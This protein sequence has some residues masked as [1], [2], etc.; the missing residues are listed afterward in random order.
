MSKAESQESA[1]FY[2]LDVT[3]S[4]SDQNMFEKMGNTRASSVIRLAPL[5]ERPKLTPIRSIGDY[6]SN[7]NI[8]VQGQGVVH[9][10]Y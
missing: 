4:R 6:T 2:T 9:E 10:K 5:S 3:K 7:T 8:Q 1:Q